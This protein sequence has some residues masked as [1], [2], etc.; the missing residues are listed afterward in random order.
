MAGIMLTFGLQIQDRHRR[1]SLERMK[2]EAET[3]LDKKLP[4]PKEHRIQAN[5]Q[6]I[7]LQ[8]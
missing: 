3:D 8:D 6:R 2:K 1:V 4:L 7:L 5:P